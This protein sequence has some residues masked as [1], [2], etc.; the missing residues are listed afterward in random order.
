MTT[1]LQERRRDEREAETYRAP[2]ADRTA[3]E[4]GGEAATPA[5]G[6]GP[7]VTGR[8]VDHREPVRVDRRG[9]LQEPQRSQRRVV[10]RI[11]WQLVYIPLRPGRHFPPPREEREIAWSRAG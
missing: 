10:G 3:G 6:L 2:G 9:P 4:G 5:V 8:A 1:S 7:G 11:L